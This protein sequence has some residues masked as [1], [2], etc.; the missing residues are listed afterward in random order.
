MIV[1]IAILEGQAGQGDALRDGLRQAR[2]VISRS[3]GYLGST[4][5]RGIE[6]PDQFILYIKWTDVAAHMEGF[7]QGQLFPE[8]RAHFVHLLANPP[9]VSHFE[10]IAG[11]D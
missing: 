8:W 2:S 6:N 7:R 1:E 3:E 10:V 9:T 4:F 5:H 11:D